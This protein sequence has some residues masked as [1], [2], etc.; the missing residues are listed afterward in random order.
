MAS[1]ESSLVGLAKQ[2]AKGVPNV[3]D[4]DFKYLLFTQGAMGPQNQVLPMDTEVGGGA[5]IRD[6]KK[7]GVTSG[8][9]LEL[10]PR[11][12]TIGLFLLGAFGAVNT[13]ADGAG[14]KHVF[15]LPA[16]QFDAPYFTMRSAPGDLWGEQ[17]EDARMS[18]FGLEFKGANFVRGQV[19]FQGGKPSKVSTAAWAAASKVD[20]TAPFITPISSVELPTGSPIKVMSGSFVAGMAI[21][22]EEQW[23]V[24]SYY[25]DAMDITSRSFAVQLAIKITDADLYSKMMYDPAGGTAW[26]TNLLREGKVKLSFVSDMEYDEGKPYKLE[27]EANGQDGDAGNVVWSAQPIGLR[28]GRQVVMAV[29]GIFLAGTD[30]ITATLYNKTASY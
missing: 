26:T 8:G 6:M 13:S 27:I 5:M 22:L 9:A 29:T 1:S 23:I 25:P 4:A 20:G 11:V 14:F 12:D 18:A 10:I 15:K 2:T 30:P 28:A 24:G 7:T 19:G 21:P 16:N 3:T 17:F